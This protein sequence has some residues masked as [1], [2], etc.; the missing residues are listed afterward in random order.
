MA[1]LRPVRHQSGLTHSCSLLLQG[2]YGLFF[3]AGGSLALP[4]VNCVSQS[5]RKAVPGG[6]FSGVSSSELGRTSGTQLTGKAKPYGQV[7]AP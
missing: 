7:Y 3:S 6:V 2:Q 4:S 5:G 1:E